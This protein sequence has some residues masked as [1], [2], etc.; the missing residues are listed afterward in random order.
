MSALLTTTMTGMR[1]V[2]DLLAEQGHA[3]RIRTIVGGA[4]VSAEFAR[5]IGADAYAFDAA[6]AVERV[7]ALVAC[8]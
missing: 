3:G 7:K 8:V 4:P 1:E 6:N 2:V 5:D